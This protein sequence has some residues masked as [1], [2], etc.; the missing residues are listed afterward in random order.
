MSLTQPN[1]TSGFDVRPATIADAKACRMLLDVVGV[2][3][4]HLVAVDRATQ[5]VIGAAALTSGR[6]T[7]PLVGLGAMVHVIP[8]CRRHGVGAALCDGL[9]TLSR[10]QGMQAIYAARRVEVDSPESHGWRFLGFTPCETVEEHV[11]PLDEFVP[12]LEPLVDSLR[13]RGRIPADAQIIP[14]HAA[15]KAQVLQLHLDHMGGERGPLYQKICGHGPGAFHQRHSRV[16]ML[17]DRV[18]GCILTHLQPE[19]IAVVDANIVAPDL[20]G[21]WANVWLKLE[22]TRG[23]LAIG[24]TR[25]HFTT[26]DHYTDTR[27]FT[28]KLGGAVARKRVLMH[29][30]LA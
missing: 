25:F 13:R 18:A 21:N 14:L 19:R 10:Q 17:G 26:F 4:R 15:D 6:R 2:E 28:E 23:A 11:L 30:P 5:R 8:P 7:T 22:A 24:I 27:T 20:R 16:L 1:V 29:R 3:A 9:I 12:R